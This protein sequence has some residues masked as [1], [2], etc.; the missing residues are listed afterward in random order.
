MRLIQT[1]LVVMV[2]EL[3]STVHPTLAGTFANELATAADLT[4]LH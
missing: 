4:K 2:V 3:C 1:L